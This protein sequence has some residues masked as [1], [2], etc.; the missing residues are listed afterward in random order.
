MAEEYS[1]NVPITELR[2]GFGR[3]F[4][5]ILIDAIIIT[6]LSGLF[7]ILTHDTVENVLAEYLS[8]QLSEQSQSL[9][10]LSDEQVDS[11]VGFTRSGIVWGFIGGLVFLFYSLMEIAYAATPGKMM[12]GIKI[13]NADGTEA[14]TRRLTT[15]W[16]VKSGLST[17]LSLLG[18]LFVSS[19]LS[20]LS[21]VISIVIF[22][23]CFMVLSAHRQ[24]LH[25]WIAQTAVYRREHIQRFS[26][27][28]A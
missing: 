1:V 22:F 16:F 23:G 13:A 3:R 9:S 6:L 17:S 18:M 21:T 24:A 8:H 12:L 7:Y 25:D 5:A 11:I 28:P 27:Q 15:R 20:S 10:E 14:P 19:L 26:D 2:I 4:G